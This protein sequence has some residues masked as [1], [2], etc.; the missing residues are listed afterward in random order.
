MGCLDVFQGRALHL[1][2]ENDGQNDHEHLPSCRLG[3]RYS[4]GCHLHRWNLLQHL[5]LHSG[6][7]GNV[8]LV[9]VC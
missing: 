9:S 6:K 3:V 1:L 2:S 7:R 5:Q 8:L 4:T